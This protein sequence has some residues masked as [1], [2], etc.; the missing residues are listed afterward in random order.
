[1]TCACACDMCMQ[2]SNYAVSMA[3]VST[4]IVAVVTESSTVLL[5]TRYSPLTTHHALRITHHALLTTHYSLR[6]PHSALRTPH[7]ALLTTTA[8]L[9]TRLRGG[10]DDRVDHRPG[11]RV[12]D[13]A[14]GLMEEAA[15]V[16]LLH[17]DEDELRP[18]LL[19]PDGDTRSADGGDLGVRG[20]AWVCM[21]M[22]GYA[23]VCM[24]R[25]P[26][27][28]GWQPLVHG[29]A[30]SGYTGMQPLLHGIVA[31]REPRVITR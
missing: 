25:R 23:W 3:A 22:H 24:G 4:A 20:Y 29:V 21:G 11:Q 18:V 14:V 5:T 2:K 7:S 31:S 9:P 28:T 13:L 16:A 1:M 17:H 26:W 27:C 12:L 8:S 6:T 30:A 10:S 15:V 19:T